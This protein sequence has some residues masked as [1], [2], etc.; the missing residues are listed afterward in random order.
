MSSTPKSIGK[1]SLFFNDLA[2][3]GTSRRNGS[4]KFTTAGQAAA[5]SALRREN[6]ATSDLPPPPMFTLEDRSDYSPESGIPDYPIVSPD[7]NSNPRTPTPTQSKLFSTSTPNSN[8]N[9]SSRVLIGNQQLQ[10]KQ[11]T[12]GSLNRWSSGGRSDGGGGD[13]EKSPVQGVVH[14]QPWELI[15]LPSLREVARPEIQRSSLSVGDLDEEEWVTVYGFSPSDTNV[16]LQEFERCGVILRHV[17]G[18]K[19]A[20]WI[21][22]L[23]QSRADAE[24]ALNKNSMQINGCL[25]IGVKPVDPMQR[26][27]LSDRPNNLG[28]MPLTRSSDVMA[29]K[30]SD[31]LQNGIRKT[32]ESGGTM[33]TSSKSMVSKIADLM[34]GV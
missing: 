27:A 33:A 8:T 30:P 12:V 9:Q 7:S 28:F 21:H 20:N 15:T 6:F 26:Q 3:P 29:F 11:S 18:P 31:R 34:F 32:S 17:P 2:S 10:S 14:H 19:D 4:G 22:I 24:K 1:Q 13:K 25:I 16:I 5:V 23:Y